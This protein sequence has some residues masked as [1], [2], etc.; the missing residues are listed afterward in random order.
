MRGFQIY[1]R[2]RCAPAHPLRKIFSACVSQSGSGNPDSDDVSSRHQTRQHYPEIYAPKERRRK[3]FPYFVG[4]YGSLANSWKR[5]E[6]GIVGLYQ[7]DTEPDSPCIQGRS[8]SIPN[9]EVELA[10]GAPPVYI[11]IVSNLVLVFVNWASIDSHV[12][13]FLACLLSILFHIILSKV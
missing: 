13:L 4:G 9:N 6:D 2:G 1:T 10:G 12:T 8:P 5:L 3:V 11:S 7:L